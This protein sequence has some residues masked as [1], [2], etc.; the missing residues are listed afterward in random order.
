M[1]ATH[2][3]V[4][5]RG[6]FFTTTIV[7]QEIQAIFTCLSSRSHIIYSDSLSTTV[8]F[9]NLVKPIALQYLGRIV[10]EAEVTKLDEY[11]III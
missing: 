5:R 7:A 8:H 9:D 11:M 3:V 2:I 6:F 4:A 10:M 1:V